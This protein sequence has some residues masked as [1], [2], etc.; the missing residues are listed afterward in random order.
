MYP[1][2]QVETGAA[3]STYSRRAWHV[4][5]REARHTI[6][7]RAVSYWPGEDQMARRRAALACIALAFAS[8][9]HAQQP[10]RLFEEFRGAWALDGAAGRGRIAGL[11]AART[12]VIATSATEISVAKDG[13]A[14]EVYRVD[15]REAPLVD[16][17]TGAELQR[18]SRFTLV[19]GGLALTSIVKR[20]GNGGPAPSPPFRLTN[21]VT[22][23]YS[24]QGDTL[25]VERQLSVLRE[26]P[27][28]LVTLADSRNNRQTIVY[29]R[30][31]EPAAP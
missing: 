6:G 5:G 24:V 1:A 21:I 13:A 4:R 28:E 9:A 11:P 8:A 16:P 3:A 7:I 26:P 22:D 12:L 17:R 29:R 30:V 19:A 25:T 15:G 10:P 14:P 20:P 23:A 31:P 2:A 27:G 18:S